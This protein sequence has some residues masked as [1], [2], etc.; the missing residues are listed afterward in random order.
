MKQPPEITALT[1]APATH[2]H[3]PVSI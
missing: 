1:A 3:I 2:I